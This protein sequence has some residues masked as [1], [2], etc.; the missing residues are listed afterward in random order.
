MR[1]PGGP[2]GH[3]TASA[4]TSLFERPVRTVVFLVHA[5]N[6]N[7]REHAYAAQGAKCFSG[8]NIRSNGVRKWT[9]V[10]CLEV[11][12]TEYGSEVSPAIARDPRH[13]GPATLRVSD[14]QQHE[15][16]HQ[17]ATPVAWRQ[18]MSPHPNVSSIGCKGRLARS[19]NRK[20]EDGGSWCIRPHPRTSWCPRPPQRFLR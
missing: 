12:A 1:L 5:S 4:P 15:V 14:V 16:R 17:R 2:A 13:A 7:L 19:G 18:A 6:T 11:Q 8:T 20:L 3:W 10:A 9:G